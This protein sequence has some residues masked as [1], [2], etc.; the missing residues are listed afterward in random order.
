MSRRFVSGVI[1][2]YKKIENQHRREN[3]R[4]QKERYH[5]SQHE[6]AEQNTMN[7]IDTYNNYNNMV[8]TL[9]GKGDLFSFEFYKKNYKQDEFVSK[10]PKPKKNQV[11]FE[12]PKLNRVPS[13]TV[14]EKFFP[15][16]KVKR[17]RIEKYNDESI[18]NV[19]LR[20]KEKEDS[21]LDKY[22][23]DIEVYKEKLEGERSKFKKKELQR[24]NEVSQHNLDIE[25]WKIRFHRGEKTSVIRFVEEII[26]L[27]RFGITFILEHNVDFNEVK[28]KFNISVYLKSR[29]DI[30]SVG[31]YKYYKTKREIL[32]VRMKITEMNERLKKL[33]IQLSVSFSYIVFANDGE[34]INEISIDFYSENVCLSSTSIDFLNYQNYEIC[35]MH[36]V[37]SYV[38]NHM[39][40]FKQYNK[41]VVEFMSK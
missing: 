5:A 40:V 12:E 27:Y 3:D 38:T 2:E 26:E 37:N 19:D 33:L 16:L 31:G 14:L 7:L 36:G 24:S 25:N 34:V 4:L 35:T 20:N 6:Y 9:Y 23:R 30:F 1:R 21:V 28:K 10:L 11:E 22:N 32:P 8:E 18:H 29:N 39:R 41:G 15:K 13:E 17:L